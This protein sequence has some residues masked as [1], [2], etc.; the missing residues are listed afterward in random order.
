MMTEV[1]TFV[2]KGWHQPGI[3]AVRINRKSF[4]IWLSRM[5]LIA[6]HKCRIKWS[7]YSRDSWNNLLFAFPT[8]VLV[9]LL[10]VRWLIG[11]ARSWSHHPPLS[12]CKSPTGPGG[13]HA[14]L[15]LYWRR[16]CCVLGTGLTE[17]PGGVFLEALEGLSIGTETTLTIFIC[18]KTKRPET[19]TYMLTW[20][21]SQKKH[22]V[23]N[24]LTDGGVEVLPHHSFTP[25][26]SIP[27]LF[28]RR[29]I[30]MHTIKRKAVSCWH[31]YFKL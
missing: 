9:L 26:L 19:Q 29:V 1:M 8:L 4:A 5:K 15:S 14:M 22:K 16:S 2:T 27:F 31:M 6:P 20:T 21:S 28:F 24:A 30:L 11:L 12:C 7:V 13:V 23:H 18:L 3:P 10:R 17:Y 25:P